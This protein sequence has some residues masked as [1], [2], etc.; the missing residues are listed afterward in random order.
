MPVDRLQIGGLHC[1]IQTLYSLICILVG[2]SIK[3][4]CNI[5][6]GL[7]AFT[8][9]DSLIAG[10][11][12]CLAEGVGSPI[13]DHSPVLKQIDP[14]CDGEGARRM[15]R[16]LYT[17]LEGI[18]SGAARNGSLARAKADYQAQFGVD[19]VDEVMPGYKPTN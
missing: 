12:K 10:V 17:Y 5:G 3:V 8:D 6:A 4:E 18:N 14:F 1:S 19:S 9:L 7:V 11:R 2:P 15:G 16:Y 13:G